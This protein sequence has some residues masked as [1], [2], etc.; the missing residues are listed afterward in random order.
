[1]NKTR[2]TVSIGN[3][4]W[5][6]PFRSNGF[7]VNDATGKSFAESRS[8]DLADATAKLLNEFYTEQENG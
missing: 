6:L 7:W 5:I 8:R 3:Q 2:R 4:I 1:M